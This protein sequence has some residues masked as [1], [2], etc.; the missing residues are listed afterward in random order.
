MVNN[1]IIGSDEKNVLRDRLIREYQE[2]K[3]GTGGYSSMLEN[4]NEE[5]QEEDQLLLG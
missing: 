5:D 4:G 2:F 3:T 1:F